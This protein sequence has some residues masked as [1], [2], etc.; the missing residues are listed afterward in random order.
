[1]NIAIWTQFE[2]C[3]GLPT[4]ALRITFETKVQTMRAAEHLTFRLDK[5]RF[6]LLYK[7]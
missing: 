7:P 1:M 4:A 5:L 6:L 2:G 3:Y